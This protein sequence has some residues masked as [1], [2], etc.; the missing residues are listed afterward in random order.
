[1]LASIDMRSL[2]KKEKMCSLN[3][4]PGGLLTL[5]LV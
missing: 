1:M 2:H 5:H 4:V 3:L